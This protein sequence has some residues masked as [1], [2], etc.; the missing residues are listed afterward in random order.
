[1]KFEDKIARLEEISEL[2]KNG[3]VDFETQIKI[4]REG[5]ALAL[6]IEN[7]LKKAQQIIEEI[8]NLPQ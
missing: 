5:S 1:M 2:I 8:D 6:E 4:Y 3:D 7:E